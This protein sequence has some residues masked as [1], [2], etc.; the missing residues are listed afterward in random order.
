MRLQRPKSLVDL[1]AEQIRR[2]I[3][4]GR[5][6]F[7]QQV[8]EVSLAESLG[9]SKTPVRE[10]LLR[11]AVEG[12]V[13]IHPQRGSFI[14]SLTPQQVSELTRFREVIE[15]AALG[16]AIRHQKSGLSERLRSNLQQLLAAEAA[17][18]TARVRELDTLFHEGIIE[19]SGNAYLRKA[20]ELI[21]YKIQALRARLPEQVKQVDDCHQSHQ[22]ILDAAASGQVDR[23]QRLLAAHIRSTEQ[24]YIEASRA[25]ERAA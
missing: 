17:G 2:L 1:A 18:D 11:L 9:T 19:C 8:S 10:A 20:Y 3:I 16:E 7:G 12:L 21:A 15:A 13:E 5:L 4:D 23:A 14:F 24:S 22:D 25:D 6:S